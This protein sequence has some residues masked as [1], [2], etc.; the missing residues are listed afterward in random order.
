MKYVPDTSVIIE[1]ALTRLIKE[2]KIKGTILIPKAVISELENQANTGRETGLIGLEELQALQKIGNVEFIGDRPNLSQIKYAKRG[3]E[4]D[5]MIK[6]LAQEHQA[7]LITADLVQAESA[8]AVGVTVMFLEPITTETIEIEKFFDETSMSVHLKENTIPFAKRGKPGA[9]ELKQ[10]QETKLTQEDVQ[11]IAK[12]IIE[13]SRIEKN[14]FIEISRRGSTIV[15]Y[16]NYRIVIVKPPVSDGLEI[17][18]VKPLKSFNLEDYK[19]PEKI[20]SRLKERAS[21][22]IIAGQVGSGKSTFAQALA[23]H[24]AANGRITKTIESPRDLILKD[25]ITQ[26]SKNF[27]SSEEIH[28]ILFLTRPDNVIFDEMRDN[29][30]F[31]LYVDLRLGGSAVIGVLHSATPIDAIQRFIGRIDVGMI[32]S[33]LDTILFINKGTIEQLFTVTMKVKVPSGMTEADLARPVIEVKDFETEKLMFEI[34]SYGEQTVV[35]PI[36]K[37]EKSPAKNLAEKQLK[38]EISKYVKNPEVELLGDH[39]ARVYVQKGDKGKLIGPKGAT[40]D[41]IEKLI[42]IGID[43][44]VKDEEIT[45]QRKLSYSLKERGNYVIINLK[46]SGKMVDVYIDNNFLFTSTT[47]KKGEIRISKKSDIGDK[48][49]EGLDM[50]KKLIIRG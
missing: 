29:P 36:T 39:K 16:K 18:A 34:Y 10:I 25:E 12:E 17:T 19:L 8:K 20:V 3:G 11:R 32:P 38:K 6:D 21:G 46:Q 22:V 23:E 2:K 41:K 30:D 31:K 49:V 35:I 28:D 14:A 44:E 48:L 37:T 45:K 26:Y 43:V 9:W 7:T 47:S 40:I 42:G 1:K 33:V 24:Y 4:I 27:A 50:N 15:Q 5:A 13:K